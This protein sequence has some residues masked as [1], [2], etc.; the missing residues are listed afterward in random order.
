MTLA[1]EVLDG[2]KGIS[3][4]E[5]SGNVKKLAKL[6]VEATGVSSKDVSQVIQSLSIINS[7]DS[8]LIKKAFEE[9]ISGFKQGRK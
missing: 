2:F 4:L 9:I 1:Q 7:N 5:E 8:G 3:K 6:V